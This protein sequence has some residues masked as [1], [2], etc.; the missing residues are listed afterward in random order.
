M[1]STECAYGNPE[2]CFGVT[3]CNQ[4]KGKTMGT[5]QKDGT[6]M[7]AFTGRKMIAEREAFLAILTHERIPYT[8]GVGPSVLCVFVEDKYGIRVREVV[9]QWYE[10]LHVVHRVVWE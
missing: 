7:Y 5:P 1:A 10:A 2:D 6:I 4:C 8:T 3:L 9:Q